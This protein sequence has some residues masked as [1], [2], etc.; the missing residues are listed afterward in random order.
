MI[1][2]KDSNG[3]NRKGIVRTVDTILDTLRNQLDLTGVK[4]GCEADKTLYH[5]CDRSNIKKVSTIEE[6]YD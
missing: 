5:V 3:E 4:H 2:K 6:L 1:I